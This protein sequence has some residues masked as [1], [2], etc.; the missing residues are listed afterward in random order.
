MRGKMGAEFPIFEKIEVN[1]Q[2]PHELFRYLRCNSELWDKKKQRAKEIP[3]NFAKFLVNPEGKVLGYY[4]PRI[5]P[6]MLI[7]DI[8]EHLSQQVIRAFSQNS[9]DNIYRGSTMPPPL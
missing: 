1:G 3:W 2:D 5:N 7:N 4:D 8:Q 6:L 9:D